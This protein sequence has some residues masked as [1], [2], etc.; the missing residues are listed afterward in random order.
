MGA[1]AGPDISTDGLVLCFDASNKLSKPKDLNIIDPSTWS[2]GSGSVGVFGQNG[3]STENYRVLDQDPFGQDAVIWE[4]RPD[5]VSNADG[6]WNTSTFS[7]DNTKMYRFSVWVK[8][9]NNIN[10]RFYLGL[11]GY[12]STNGVY[13]RSNGSNNTNPYFY[14]SI[15]FFDSEVWYLVVGHVWAD[16]SGTGSSYVDSGIYTVNGGKVANINSDYVWRSETTSARHRTYLYYGTDTNQRQQFAYPRVDVIDGTEP[17]IED[18]LNNKINKSYVFD[19]SKQKSLSTLIN[20][21][22]VDESNIKSIYFDGSNDYIDC[23]NPAQNFTITDQYTIIVWLKRDNSGGGTYNGTFQITEEGSPYEAW[24]LYIR[25]SDG[26]IGRYAG[27][28][29]YSTNYAPNNEWCMVAG[30][31]LK[32]TSG[33]FASSLNG[34]PWQTFYTADT[35]TNLN[36]VSTT[37]SNIGRWTGNAHYLKG[38][39]ACVQVYNRIL[40]TQEIK[41]NYNALKGRFNL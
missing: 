7:I 22:S 6:G 30:C 26:A 27:G 20:G 5:S 16:G 21:V 24:E 31:G 18:L 3:G 35:T 40:T 23:G 28:W 9:N 12:G 34:S 36:I 32:S 4:A 15:T 1:A 17:S 8:R 39:I 11:N 19:I 10:G 38:N 2:I 29:R 41:Q 33:Y 13:L 25:K 37:S 14:N